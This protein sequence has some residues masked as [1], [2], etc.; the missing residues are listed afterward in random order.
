MKPNDP[1]SPCILDGNDAA[2]PI[3]W[4]GIDLRTYLAAMAMQGLLAQHQSVECESGA[5][6]LDPR[7]SNPIFAARDA[8]RQ[9]D[10]L[11]AELNK[12][13]KESS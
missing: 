3:Q 2:Y 11:I 9:A 5:R 6:D 7:Y 13:A 12:P 8:V 1:V 4:S 10:A